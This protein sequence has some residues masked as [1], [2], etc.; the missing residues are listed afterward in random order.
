MKL[1]DATYLGQFEDGE[2]HGEGTYVP[3]NGHPYKGKWRH[4][5]RHGYGEMML[6]NGLFYKG[7][8]E[9]DKCIGKA[10]VEITTTHFAVGTFTEYG[11]GKAKIIGDTYTVGKSLC[12]VVYD[13]E[14]V[15]YCKYHGE[16]K[17]KFTDIGLTY[18]GEFRNN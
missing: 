11:R 16:G 12:K 2:F 8:F 13:G 3:T 17:L 4:G 9:E 5:K 14:V 15:N 7:N 6:D 18:D 10:K 1:K